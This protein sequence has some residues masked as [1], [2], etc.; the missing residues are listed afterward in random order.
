MNFSPTNSGI[1]C[2]SICVGGAVS[3]ASREGVKA[4]RIGGRLPYTRGPGIP[5]PYMGGDKKAHRVPKQTRCAYL[6]YPK[7]YASNGLQAS[8]S[9]SFLASASARSLPLVVK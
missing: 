7:F 3:S 8:A 9:F 1:V 2:G 4:L 5:G 6:R